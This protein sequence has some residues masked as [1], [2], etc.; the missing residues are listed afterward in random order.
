[1]SARFDTDV[2][3]TCQYFDKQPTAPVGLCRFLPPTATGIPMQKHG[4]DGKVHIEVQQVN[5]WANTRPEDWCAQHSVAASF[6]PHS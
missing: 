3:A 2:C 6:R 5:M 4:L 1:M